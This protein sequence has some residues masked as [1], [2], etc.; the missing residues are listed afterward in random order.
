MEDAITKVKREAIEAE[1]IT[2]PKETKEHKSRFT[3]RLENRKKAILDKLV[4]KYFTERSALKDPD[5]LESACLFDKYENEWRWECKTFNRLRQ[6]FKLRYEAFAESVEYYIKMEK[7][8]ITQTAEVNKTKDFDHWFRRAHVWRTRPLTAA[9]FWIKSLGN[10][11]K[12]LKLW[13]N[14][15]ISILSMKNT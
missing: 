10:H 6:P 11:E 12:R 5:G 13:K 2:P 9:Y 8:Q 7:A 15:Y 1:G 14:V 4:L 3:R